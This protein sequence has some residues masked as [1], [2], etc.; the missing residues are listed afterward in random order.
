MSYDIFI[1]YRREGGDTLAQLI[2]DR[3]TARGYRVFLDIESLRSGK[4]NEKLLSVMEECKD[5]VAILPPKGLERCSNPEDWVYR[6]LAYAIENRKNIIPIMMKGFSWPEELPEA[7]RE[8]PNFNGILDSKDYFDAVIDKIA[9]LLRSK[10]AVFHGVFG[11][12]RKEKKKSSLKSYMAR[13][14]KMMISALCVILLIGVG[15]GVFYYQKNEKRK[16]LARNIS[17][18]LTASDDMTPAEYYD[19]IEL[20]KERIKIFAGDKKYSLEVQNEKIEL[21][22]PMDAFGEIDVSEYLRCYLTRSME[23]YLKDL[24][25]EQILEVDGSDIENLE[26]KS[27]T[28]E[29]LSL[30]DYF[31]EYAQKKNPSLVNMEEYNYFEL[32]FTDEFQK[33]VE[34]TFDADGNSL[35][36][37]QDVQVNP[38][39]YY[40]YLLVPGK[41]GNYYFLDNYQDDTAAE[42]VLHNYTSERLPEIFLFNILLP[43]EWEYEKKNSEWGSCQRN[44]E[45][46]SG[47]LVTLQY[48]AYES[49][50]TEGNKQD[51]LRVFR[52]RLDKLGT[53]Y[54]IGQTVSSDYGIS[55]KMPAEHLDDLIVKWLGEKYPVIYLGNRFYSAVSLGKD[56]LSLHENQDGTYQMSLSIN[57]FYMKNWS[58]L[59]EQVS[60]SSHTDLWFRIGEIPVAR[61]TPETV[62]ESLDTGILNVY[63]LDIWKIDTIT[64]EYRY[65]PEFLEELTQGIQMPIGFNCSQVRFENAEDTEPVF[66]LQTVTS[67]KERELEEKIRQICPTAEISG[68]VGDSLK[69][70]LELETDAKMP[71]KAISLIKQIYELTDFEQE[72]YFSTLYVRCDAQNNIGFF[73]RSDR[74]TTHEITWEYMINNELFGEE[75][76]EQFRQL[77][78]KDSFFTETVIPKED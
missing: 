49:D 1:S 71:E 42:L 28:V 29:E 25:S 11:N 60:D 46:L 53:P 19:A 22:I 34:E 41:D 35:I 48:D 12:L 32:T 55:I 66:P 54:A 17:I 14:K 16:E 13:R 63:H 58:E 8:L 9:L 5:V 76:E 6:E 43:V 75:Y 69:V 77:V 10:P 30:S 62:E 24:N 44:V 27:G 4:F 7:L 36:L 23:L 56:S 20:L 45:D 59:V 52:N 2:Y 73:F 3:L 65:L 78:E 31:P 61:C 74:Y 39:S 64:E 72:E 26:Y 57:D 38:Y 67:E 18:V 40:Y 37:A 47:K 70:W 50:V 21:T 51:V 68:D 15:A 33:K